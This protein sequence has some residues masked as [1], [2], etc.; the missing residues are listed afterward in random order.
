MCPPG[1][2]KLD[3]SPV[4]DTPLACLSTEL[5]PLIPVAEKNI[6]PIKEVLEFPS[7]EVF[8]PHNIYRWVPITPSFY[9]ITQF[10]ESFVCEPVCQSKGKPLTQNLH[11]NRMKYKQQYKGFEKQMI[12]SLKRKQVCL[13]SQTV[14]FSQ[15]PEATRAVML[16]S[17]LKSWHHFAALWLRSF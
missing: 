7:S 16:H 15:R 1:A 2:I 14:Y 5:I 9:T 6:R 12:N 3:M 17:S 8:V 10:F 11:L 13:L 4:H